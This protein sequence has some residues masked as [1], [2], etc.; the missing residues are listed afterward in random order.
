MPFNIPAE[1]TAKALNDFAKAAQIHLLFPFDAASRFS[2]PAIEG[3]FTRDQVL[4]KLLANTDLEVAGEASDTITL[5]EKSMAAAAEPTTQVTVTGSRIRGVPPTSPVHVV[6]RDDIDQSGYAEVGDLVRSL[7]EDFSGG[8]NPGVINASASNIGN[9]NFSNASTVNLRGLGTDATLVLV[10]GH[11]LSADSFFQGS[12][13]SGIPLGAIERVEVVPDGASALY[14]SDAVAGVVNF[15]LRKN[16]NG[17]QLSTTLGGATQGGG[18]D[19][20]YSVL[21]GSAGKTWHVLF[22]AEYEK[23]DGITAG[24][25]DIAADAVPAS[26][27]L[28]PHDRHSVFADAGV[29]LTDHVDLSFEGLLDDRSFTSF[30]QSAPTAEVITVAGYAPS[31][32]ATVS[33]NADLGGGWRG[34]LTDSIAGSRDAIHTWTDG[35]FSGSIDRNQMNTIELTGDG[36]L[37]QLPGGPLKVAAGGGY[38]SEGY[39]S[40]WPG[41]LSYIDAKRHVTY[42]FAEAEIPIVSPSP[43]R[44]GLHELELN[45]SGRAEDYSDFG[46]SANPKVGLRYVPFSDLALHATWG[47]SLKAPSFEQMYELRYVIDWNAAILGGSP[48]NTA[49]EDGGGNPDLKPET[50][51][52]WTFGGDYT[53]QAIPGL[54]VSADWFNIDYHNRVVQPVNDI[55]VGLTDPIYAPFVEANPSAGRQAQLISS[56]SLFLNYSGAAYNPA[57]VTDIL[58]DDYENATSQTVRGLDLGYRQVFHAPGGEIDTFANA[59]WLNLKQRTLPAVPDVTLSGTVFN[60]PDFK[61]RGGL[62]WRSGALTATGIVNYISSETDTGVIPNSRI[63]SWTTFDATVAY[64]FGNGADVARA[65]KVALS[66]TNLFDRNPPYAASPGLAYTGL[67]FDSTNSSIIGRFVSLTLTKAW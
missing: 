22:D 38:R 35:S 52:S 16:Y 8:Q 58:N 24:Q 4:A 61:G 44:I 34:H 19:Q 67:N 39:I 18:F 36:T 55:T 17:T 56:A 9:Q 48:K 53:P 30:D 47:A 26:T 46:K 27:L 15:I 42:A 12:D 51:R 14:G 59:T 45:V 43:D 1:N 13:I 31:Y 7:P 25:R 41:G 57:S 23:Q 28:N 64:T 40:Q 49:L 60:P 29:D 3:N 65:F 32:D 5:R 66:A 37:L 20:T 33:L 63:G 21:T 11:R 54:K 62:T 6:T 2:A 50:S 10:D